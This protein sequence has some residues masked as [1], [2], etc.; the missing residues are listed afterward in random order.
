MDVSLSELRELVMDRGIKLLAHDDI[1]PMVVIFVIPGPVVV[2]RLF[3]DK[4]MGIRGPSQIP[5][6]LKDFCPWGGVPFGSGARRLAQP[7]LHVPRLS[8]FTI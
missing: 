1:Q 2:L 7:R 6:C 4:G 8:W 5:R 3:F